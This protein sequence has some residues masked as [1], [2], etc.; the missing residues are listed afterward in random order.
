MTNQILRSVGRY[1]KPQK[2]PLNFLRQTQKRRPRRAQVGAALCFFCGCLSGL[3]LGGAWGVRLS[4]FWGKTIGQKKVGT[5]R[6]FK[7]LSTGLLLSTG[8]ITGLYF[9]HAQDAATSVQNGTAL[10]GSANVNWSSAS[11][12][13]AMLQA[14]ESSGPPL[15]PGQLPA[16]ACGYYSAQH[17]DFPPF[18][19]NILNLYGW[20]LGNGLVLLDDLNVNYQSLAQAQANGGIHPR[21]VS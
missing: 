10:S 8:L 15:P 13:Q 20:P 11:D 9:L 16:D 6:T 14:I 4:V 3:P 7:N 12:L 21:A 1:S 5:M 2:N 19:G 17:P 18:P